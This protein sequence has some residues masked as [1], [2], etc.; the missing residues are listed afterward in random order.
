MK[1]VEV[2]REA[3]LTR[4]AAR[5]F[6]LTLVRLSYVDTDG[7]NYWLSP[8][9]LELGYAYLS[10]LSWPEAARPHVERLVAEIEDAS[11]VALLD[12]ADVVF[13]LRVPGPQLINFSIGVGTRL[14]AHA[15][16][17]GKVLLAGLPNPEVENY[18]ATARLQAR[19]RRT[20]ISADELRAELMDV[21]ENGWATGN[22]ELE[23][24]LRTI[25]VPLCDRHDRIVAALSVSSHIM[26]RSM[27]SMRRD[28]LPGLQATAAQIEGDMH[29][30]AHINHRDH[31]SERS[32]AQPTADSPEAPGRRRPATSVR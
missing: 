19:T 10:G 27:E 11:E 28:V 25:A 26:R 6:L 14:P 31:L 9:V 8:R 24:G 5:R 17:S 30:A 12:G 15:L 2:S 20:I 23:E 29:A 32:T 21:R 7:R 16:A 18:L 13:V 3:G 4:A 22:Q 1:L